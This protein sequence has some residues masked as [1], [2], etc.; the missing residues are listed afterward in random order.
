MKWKLI[1]SLCRDET[2]DIGPASNQLRIVEI[3]RELNESAL[4]KKDSKGNAEVE[5]S[6]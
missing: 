2:F 1:R 5:T 3:C 6:V 4:V